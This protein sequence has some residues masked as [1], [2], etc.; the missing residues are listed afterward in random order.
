MASDEDW[1][2]QSHSFS[3]DNEISNI[4]SEDGDFCQDYLAPLS[5]TLPQGEDDANPN[6]SF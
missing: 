1:Y 2:V 3:K 4:F 6:K 5:P